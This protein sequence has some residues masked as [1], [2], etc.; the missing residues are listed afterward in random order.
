MTNI[1]AFFKEINNKCFNKKK[2]NDEKEV[3]KK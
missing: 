2:R 3:L 1:I